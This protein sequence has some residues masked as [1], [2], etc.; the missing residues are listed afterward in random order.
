MQS[1]SDAF[2]FY[3]RATGAE[4]GSTLVIWVPTVPERARPTISSSSGLDDVEIIDVDGGAFVTGT[5]KGADY[6]L[7]LI[8][9]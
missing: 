6:A 1:D 3:M 4:L 2:A 8:G 5:T 7:D 9:E